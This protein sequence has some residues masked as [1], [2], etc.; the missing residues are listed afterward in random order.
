MVGKI[1]MILAIIAT[2]VSA[3]MAVLV[4][5]IVGGTLFEVYSTTYLVDWSNPSDLF[6]LLLIYAPLP[7]WLAFFLSRFAR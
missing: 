4:V 6:M 2:C 5:L 1:L 3:C 7:L